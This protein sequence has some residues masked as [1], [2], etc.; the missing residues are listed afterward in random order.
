[1]R[2]RDRV[3]VQVRA[4]GDDYARSRAAEHPGRI[5][6]TN[7]N[8]RDEAVILEKS[9]DGQFL[10]KFDD[11]EEDT[12]WPRKQ[13]RFVS[14]P[15]D[16]VNPRTLA[17]REVGDEEDSDE[18]DPEEENSDESVN[19]DEEQS[20]ASSTDAGEAESD[21]GG[22]ALANDTEGWIRDDESANDERKR[23]GS[24]SDHAPTWS[25]NGQWYA[26]KT[27]SDPAAFF[28]ACKSWFDMKFIADMADQMQTKGREKGKNWA[29]WRVTESDVLQWLGVWYYM[30]AFPQIGDRRD[31]FTPRNEQWR[32][33]PRH[34]IEEWLKRGDNGTYKGI[35]WFEN[36]E[37]CFSLPTVDDQTARDN[38]KF[39]EVRHMWESFRKHF[40]DQV[41]P[42]WLVC[43]DESMIKWMGC[44]MPG[45]MTVPRKPTPIG[46]ELHTL[47]DAQSGVLVNYEVYEGKEAMEKKKFVF[48]KT[49]IGEINKST[50]LTLRMLEPYFSTG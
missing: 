48:D 2:E 4:F 17:R 47:C 19:F 6:Y 36:M 1:M 7:E 15:E 42:G 29:G 35:T 30:L 13:L 34:F 49:D 50:A 37:Q 46:L 24:Y 23:S 40:V 18:V 11:I 27:E 31:Y 43:L 20:D 14:R 39:F 45:L 41:S 28:S 5:A 25:N 33:G 8:L 22:T 21:D 38:D 3:S 44:G 9:N 32:F 16:S 12:W 26:N 10:L